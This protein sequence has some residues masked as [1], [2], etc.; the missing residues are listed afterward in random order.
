MYCKKCGTDNP[1]E[2]LFCKNCGL[3][4][5]EKKETKHC[6]HC[7]QENDTETVFCKKCGQQVITDFNEVDI[8][9]GKIY[10]EGGAIQIGLSILIGLSGVGFPFAIFGFVFQDEGAGIIGLII[11]G[12]GIVIGLIVIVYSLIVP[13]INIELKPAENILMV[14]KGIIENFYLTNKRLLSQGRNKNRWSF[15]LK[16]K[17]IEIKLWTNF[18]GKQKGIVISQK[19]EEKREIELEKPQKWYDKIVELRNS[20]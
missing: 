20:K 18:W 7:K 5:V 8:E 4:I 11:A 9:N 1:D 13:K 16:S 12:F 15:S 3:E 17:E 14:K 2:A 10:K 6:P 19:Y